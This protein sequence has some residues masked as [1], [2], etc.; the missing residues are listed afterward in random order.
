M[1]WEGSRYETE[2]SGGSG[3]SCVVFRRRAVGCDAA[4]FRG[5]RRRPCDVVVD[6]GGSI[7]AQ[8]ACAR[9]ARI[10]FPLAVLQRRRQDQFARRDHHRAGRRSGEEARRRRSR[11]ANA[12]ASN[13]SRR[14]SSASNYFDG[15][16]D[17]GTRID[18]NNPKVNSGNQH[19]PF[20]KQPFRSWPN[21]LALT[22]DGRQALR[23]AA[24]P[25][26]LSRLARRG[27]RHRTRR[28]LRWIDL[29]VPGQPRGT[30][31]IG[32]AV[33]SAEHGHLSPAVCGR[34]QPIRQLRE[35]HRHRQR[36][37]H[38]PVRDRLLRRG[39]RLQ[40]RRHAPLSH[41]SLHG[42]GPRVPDRSWSDL[43]ADCRDPD[44]QHRSR[45]GESARSRD[46]RRRRTLY[47][48]N[49][50]GHTIAVINI[51]GDANTLVRTMPVGGLATD[52][53]VAGRW[54]I[55]CGPID[56]QRAESAGNGPRPAE[57]RRA[58]SPSATTVNRS[59]T[60]RS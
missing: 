47:V 18:P 4:G 1:S 54:G 16:P 8:G 21:A 20:V 40:C 52:V 49:T 46:Q 48:G 10:A 35:R 25:R 51:A 13:A 29:R 24:G 59:A 41:R 28:V 38:R 2:V 5:Q 55:V 42:S 22:P 12:P 36:R 39:S 7:R 26:R 34:R 50:L 17:P 11:R 15:R 43:H 58:A 30:R 33:S 31:P 27:G 32:I 56:Q 37:G 57:N 45:P 3:E 14:S 44:G 53:K 23:H 19:W 60:R 6:A 9:A